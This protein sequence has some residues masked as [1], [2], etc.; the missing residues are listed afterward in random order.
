MQSV[1]D[2]DWTALSDVAEKIDRLNGRFET[3]PATSHPHPVNNAPIAT[4]A[5]STNL[6]TMHVIFP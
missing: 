6:R 3:L 4:R 5:S 2:Q 1:L